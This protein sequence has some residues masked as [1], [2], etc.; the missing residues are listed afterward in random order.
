MSRARFYGV[1]LA[2]AVLLGCASTPVDPGPQPA[3]CGGDAS[4]TTPY[5]ATSV[6]VAQDSGTVLLLVVTMHKIDP[7]FTGHITVTPAP[8]LLSVTNASNGDTTLT[9]RPNVG[10]KQVGVSFTVSCLDKTGTIT[11]SWT[12]DP[13]DGR[14]D[15]VVVAL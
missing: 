5:S 9:L 13:V 14:S 2:A 7:N 3:K 12:A 15:P 6:W 11:A 8:Q 10:L 1:S 4:T